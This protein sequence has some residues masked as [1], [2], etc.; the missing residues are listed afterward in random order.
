[1][2]KYLESSNP[3]LGNVVVTADV[4]VEHDDR[5]VVTSTTRV[6]V[7]RCIYVSHPGI[8]GKVSGEGHFVPSEAS[9]VM[10]IADHRS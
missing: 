9:H 8:L 10:T 1:M 7:E 5:S 3:Q 4:L 2:G 6:Q